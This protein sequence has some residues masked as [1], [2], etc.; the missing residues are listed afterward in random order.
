MIWTSALALFVV[1]SQSE[2]ESWNATQKAAQLGWAS[3]VASLDV[4]GAFGSPADTFNFYSTWTAQRDQPDARRMLVIR[5]ASLAS[6][7]AVWTS[8]QSCPAVTK[9][10]EDLE[11]LEP[12]RIDIVGVGHDAHPSLP[13]D[14]VTYRLEVRWPQWQEGSGYTLSFS[15]NV[16]TPLANW[17]RELYRATVECWSETAPKAA[18][19]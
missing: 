11:A 3:P 6:Q 17:A 13:L 5:R 9:V 2:W 4:Q 18:G 7:G 10:F 15:S 16:N 19:Q 1:A 14:G 8:S 12:P